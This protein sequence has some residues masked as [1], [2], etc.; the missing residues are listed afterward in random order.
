[1]KKLTIEQLVEETK[2]RSQDQQKTKDRFSDLSS[3]VKSSDAVQQAIIETTRVLLTYLSDNNLT[4]EVKNF[5]APVTSVETP[6]V[7]KVVKAVN[8][9]E[10]SLKAKGTDFTPVVEALKEIESCVDK[11]PKEY[12]KPP[13][14]LKSVEINNLKQLVD[15][16]KKVSD[17]IDKQKL[18]P[19]I[20]VKPTDV[21]IDLKPL[22]EKLEKLLE[23]EFSKEIEF[24]EIPET[25][26]APLATAIQEVKDAINNQQ[27]PV[28][29]FTSAFQDSDGPTPAT[30]EADG[31]IPVATT[32]RVLKKLIDDTTTANVTYIGE[33]VLGSATGDS[34]WRIKKIDESSGVSITWSGTG[35]DAEWDERATTVVYT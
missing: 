33:A 1:M 18:D 32:G 9:L 35:F 17:K 25:D 10:S 8:N 23:K 28:P 19:K 3:L 14:P 7:A 6:D 4:T 26:L 5:P 34:V 20:T 16:V 21:K 30:L 31:L 13:E 29:N 11:L 22:E 24:P 15:E 2:Q 27:F 12:P